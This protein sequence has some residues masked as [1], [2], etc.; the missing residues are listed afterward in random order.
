M[1]N[2]YFSFKLFTVRQPRSAMKVGTD[3][4]VLGAWF[5]TGPAGCRILDVGTGTGLIALMAAQRNASACVD[6]VEIDTPSCLDAAENFAGSPWHDRLTLF[7]ESFASF[8]AR[9]SGERYDRI[10]S[11]PPY[12][13]RSLE[14]PDGARTTA[15]HAGSLPYEE[16][17]GRSCCLLAPEGS[18]SV[19]LP[20]SAEREFT[21]A[22]LCAGLYRSRI[23]YVC[24][25]AGADPKRVCMEF[26]FG[27]RSETVASLTLLDENRTP[28]A[29]YR[30][31]TGD[32]YLRM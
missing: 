17:V 5:D 22:A 2:D 15:R 16:L 13:V 26:R 25:F 19:I 32:F 21:L 20:C 29:E 31:L 11:N 27:E 14:S 8:C 23:L 6:A 9:Y 12:F 1:A 24:P 7:G 10:V 3:G 18:L 4:V 28:G 30:A